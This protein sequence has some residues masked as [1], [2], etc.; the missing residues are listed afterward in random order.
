V[1]N[2]NIQVVQPTTPAQYY[3]LLRRQAVRQWRKPLIVL[4]PK[5]LLRHP[6]V[7]STLDDCASGRFQRLLPDAEN[8]RNIKRLLLCTGKVYYDLAAFREEHQRHDV[9]VIRLEQLYPLH[10][11]RL[12]KLLAA[13]ADHVPALWVQEEPANMGAWRYLH[14]K[15]GKKLFDRFPF[16]L[17]SRLEAASPASGSAHA[18]KQ[19]QA[20]LVRRAFGVAETEHSSGGDTEKTKSVELTGAHVELTGAHDMKPS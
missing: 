17:I 1:A 20:N 6:N 9:A 8:A 13:Y 4:T 14:E 3:H 18:H 15:F 5:S 10:P 2:D 16:A 12:E 19:E 11:G 7:V